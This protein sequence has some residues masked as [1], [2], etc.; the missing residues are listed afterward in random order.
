MNNKGLTLIE[1]IISILLFGIIISFIYIFFLKGID[2]LEQN[3]SD[4]LRAKNVY[5][6]LN[7]LQRDY[8]FA[9]SNIY[10]DSSNL[11][12]SSYLNADTSLISFNY[13]YDTLIL[14]I[15]NS[16]YNDTGVIKN[17]DNVTFNIIKPDTWNYTDTNLLVKVK[18]GNKNYNGKF[19]SI[20]DQ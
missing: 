19:N 11:R 18:C 9:A 15:Y 12:F 10:C 4:S 5:N 14:Y 7:M 20:N 6:F 13:K 1:L 3:N 8:W 17:F 16:R 2:L